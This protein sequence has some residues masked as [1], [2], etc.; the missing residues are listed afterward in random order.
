MHFKNKALTRRITRLLL[1]VWIAPVPLGASWVQNMMPQKG[2]LVLMPSTAQVQHQLQ[3][4]T[5]EET[6]QPTVYMLFP[7]D[8]E[9]QITVTVVPK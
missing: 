9:E 3:Y 4:G 5:L 1:W 7:V 2:K 6:I 8:P